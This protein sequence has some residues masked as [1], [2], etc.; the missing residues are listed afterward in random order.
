MIKK[1]PPWRDTTAAARDPVCADT[2]AAFGSRCIC[3]T[4]FLRP[5]ALARAMWVNARHALSAAQT[6]PSQNF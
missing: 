6:Q 5:D 4:R 3:V 1:D 2:F